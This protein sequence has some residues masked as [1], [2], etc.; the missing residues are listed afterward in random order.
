M[1]EPPA[2]SDTGL[3]GPLFLRKLRKKRD[4]GSA[5]DD[6]EERLAL[7]RE[8]VFL[9]DERPYSLFRV[10][11]DEEL[12]RVTMGINGGRASLREDVFY[13]P[14]LPNELTDAGIAFSQTPGDTSC[15]MANRLH[16]DADASED[17]LSRLCRQLIHSSRE[18][19]PLKKSRLTPWVELVR[20]EGCLADATSENCNVSGCE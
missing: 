18:I 8:A 2:L 13:V 4:W 17:Q 10:S 9:S 15:R 11:D 6:P 20:S 5:E 14:I 1:A 19:L 12:R 3:E 16:F 7:V